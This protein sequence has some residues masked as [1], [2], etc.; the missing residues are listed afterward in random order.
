MIEAAELRAEGIWV[1]MK[2]RSNAAA[3]SVLSDIGDGT[4]RGLSIGYQ[5]AEWQETR[6][7]NNRIRIAKRWAP[8]EVS[9]V[10]VPADPGAHFRNG[11]NHMPEQE[12]NAGECEE[13]GLPQKC[14]AHGLRKRGATLMAQR[15]ANEFQIMSFLGRKTTREALRYVRAAKRPE[16]AEQGMRLA[17]QGEHNFSNLSKWLDKTSP[18]NSEK[19]GRN[20]KS[21]DPGRIRTCN[22]PL[23]RGLLYPVEPRDLQA[24]P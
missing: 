2:F 6:D 18:Q 8:I 23:R 7:G 5:V 11:E 24:L 22:L 21:G 14:R 16:M 20:K 3:L 12:Q 4:L 19:K 10:P 15:G 1:R 9:V 17:H 13:A